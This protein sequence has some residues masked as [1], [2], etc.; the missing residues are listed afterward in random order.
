MSVERTHG[1]ASEAEPAR[2]QGTVA[3]HVALAA[4]EPNKEKSSQEDQN[5]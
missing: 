4:L 2:W 5:L 1:R 3:F